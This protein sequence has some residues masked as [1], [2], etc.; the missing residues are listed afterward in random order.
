MK[1]IPGIEE[2]IKGDVEE[3]MEQNKPE[4]HGGD[5]IVAMEKG[6]KDES[7]S[8]DEGVEDVKKFKQ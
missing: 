4:L 8:K 3:Q 7:E 6:K 1:R 2:A 5:E